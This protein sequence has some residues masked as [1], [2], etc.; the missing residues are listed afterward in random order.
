VSIQDDIMARAMLEAAVRECGT[1]V[2]RECHWESVDL[3]TPVEC[4]VRDDGARVL[5]LGER[6]SESEDD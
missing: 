4:K 5:T 2:I 6:E 1:L 3:E